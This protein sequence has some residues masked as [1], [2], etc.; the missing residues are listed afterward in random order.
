MR[1]EPRST[2]KD[3]ADACGVSEATVSYLINGKRALKPATRER[4]LSKMRELNYHPSALAR[5][6]ANKRVQTL[7]VLFGAVGTVDFFTNP[8]ASGLLKGIMDSAQI[9]GFDVTL[10]TAQ[11]QSAAISAPPLGDGRTNGI[12]AIAPTLHSD[13]IEGVNSLGMPIVAISADPDAPVANVDVDNFAG[14]HLATNHLIEL[15]HRHIAY[16]SG[17]DDLASYAPR[18]D[19]FLSAMKSAHLEVRPD[20]VVNSRF[21]G[22]LPFEQARELMGS[23]DRP[24]A[25]VA[26][27][28]T[29]AIAVME[30]ARMQGLRV[31]EDFSVVGFDDVPVAQFLHPALTTI[32]QPLREI[33]ETAA[34][35]LIGAMR[36]G[37]AVAPVRQILTPELVMR[38]TTAKPV[39]KA[40]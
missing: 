31:P 23:P 9:E 37:N 20:W 29:I 21:F 24:S 39:A 4:I 13:I 10:F 11:W 25:F 34:R 38:E 14:S 12:L 6:L 15:G 26:G 35:L 3:V 27:N 2:I 19:G 8:Y 1:R 40:S 5:G 28:D 17:D 7:G 36:E 33:G 16:L 18:R 32:R 22:P 30:A